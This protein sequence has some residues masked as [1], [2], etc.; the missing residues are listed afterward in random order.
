MDATAN[1]SLRFAPAP[2]S[3][4]ETTDRILSRQALQRI[5]TGMSLVTLAL[6]FWVFGMLIFINRHQADL[7]GLAG[8]VPL[9]WSVALV[10]FWWLRFSL[11]PLAHTGGSM[12]DVFSRLPSG[13]NP[14]VSISLVPSQPWL[15]LSRLASDLA[16]TRVEAC[17][18]IGVLRIV[19]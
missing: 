4:V 6:G 10:L 14:P 9:R 2:E 7:N 15:L 11:S 1:F 16:S 3:K 18:R 17:I 12:P 13:A 19:P 8:A 5:W